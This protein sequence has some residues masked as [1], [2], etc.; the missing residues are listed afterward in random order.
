MTALVYSSVFDLTSTYF[1]IAGI[2]GINPLIGST[3]SVTFARFETQV[4]LQYEFDI[5]DLSSNFS[6]GYIP[7]GAKVPLE[8]PKGIYGTEVFELNDALRQK[9]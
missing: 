5:R 2:A 7:F 8:Y 3:G 1:L 6:S 4:A 9:V